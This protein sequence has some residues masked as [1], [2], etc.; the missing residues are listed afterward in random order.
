MRL[1][2]GLFGPG[3]R[4]AWPFALMTISS[5]ASPYRYLTVF[6]SHYP[7]QNYR[8]AIEIYDDRP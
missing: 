3:R 1:K 5:E 8:I 6:D 2:V 7:G 4:P